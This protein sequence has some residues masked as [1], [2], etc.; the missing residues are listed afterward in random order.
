MKKNNTLNYEEVL[1]FYKNKKVLITG[2]TGFKGSWLTHIL[3]SAGAKVTGYSLQPPTEPSLFSIIKLDR[4]ERYIEKLNQVYADV[5]DLE[6]LTSVFEESKPEIVFHLAAQPI[7]RES[8]RNPVET[9]ATNVMGTV[10]ICECIRLSAMSSEEN[11]T[12]ENEYKGVKSFLNVTTDKVYRNNEWEWG[13][14]ETDFLDGFDPYSNSKSCSELVTHSYRNAFFTPIDG[15]EALVRISTA[16]AG[17][18]IGGGDFSK[19]RIIPDC[20]RSLTSA[21]PVGKR[22][23]LVTVRN[24][25]STRP[26]EHV[27]EPLFA[28]MLIAKAQ[29]E[30]S[31]YAAYYNVGPDDQDCISTGDLVTLFCDS[32]NKNIFEC[33]RSASKK[34]KAPTICWINKA[35]SDAPHEAN[36]LKL[37]CSRLKSVF[38]WSPTWHVS[39]AIENVIEWTKVWLDGGD[40]L[41]EMDREIKKFVDDS[42]R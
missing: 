7:V 21:A 18:V 20:I 23:R 5:R 40:I 38:G 6:K 31:K 29:Y 37:D 30:D 4:T 34:G 8:Y 1:A 15:G 2:N 3:L 11:I 27:L 26:Y 13:Y 22:E 25:Y 28:Y 12:Y 17:N 36:F 42:V 39:E 14:R 10:N 41:A 9:Y 16:R 19:D 33:E 32:W 35:E 24:P